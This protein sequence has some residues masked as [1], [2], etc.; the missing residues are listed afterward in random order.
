MHREKGKSQKG[1]TLLFDRRAGRILSVRTRKMRLE[2]TRC[3]CVERLKTS[4]I[5]AAIHS[6]KV[7][8]ILSSE[9]THLELVA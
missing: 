1:C 3:V 2:H 6:S 9:T 4:H 8:L 5:D 7:S